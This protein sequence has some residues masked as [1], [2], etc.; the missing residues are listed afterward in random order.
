MKKK[1][2][3]QQTFPRLFST[4]NPRGSRSYFTR[5]FSVLLTSL[6]PNRC[7][8]C[9]KLPPNHSFIC[10]KCYESIT[11]V[12]QPFCYSCGKP[13]TSAETEYCQDC[14]IHRKSFT[15]GYALAVYDSVT[16]P[17]LA[18]IKYKNKRH[19]L[20]FY[21]QETLKVY[22]SLFARSSFDAILPVPVHPKRFKKRGYNQASLFADRLGAA[23]HIPVYHS[24]LVRTVNTR[25]QK[26]LSP[27][28]R[29]KNLQKAFSLYPGYEQALLPF[30][31]VL[32]VDDI[33]TTGSTMEALT[34]LLK[35]H[36][37]REVYVFSICIGKGYQ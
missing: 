8:I 27:E 5:L 7:P 31:R 17:S 36:G 35:S 28:A 6:Y 2:F 13:L 21:V 18:A 3:L 22:G 19:Y 37:V 30:E 25:P 26:E 34:R 20:D 24:L 12:R 32:L 15:R 23:L 10:T 16:R 4:K 11:F 33:Y 9:G 1:N 29:L 14:L